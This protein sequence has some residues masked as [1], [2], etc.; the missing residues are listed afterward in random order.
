MQ[1]PP[2]SNSEY[3]KAYR[4][5]H[6]IKDTRYLGLDKIEPIFI[7]LDGES[8]EVIVPYFQSALYHLH[9]SKNA[10]WEE[11]YSTHKDAETWREFTE[12]ILKAGGIRLYSGKYRNDWENVVPLHL[13]RNRGLFPDEI[14]ELFNRD[15]P[16]FGIYDENTLWERLS[17]YQLY[18]NNLTDVPPP[19]PL[20]SVYKPY[21]N[22]PDKFIL[23]SASD[24]SEIFNRE[25]GLSTLVCFEFLL[26]LASRLNG[27]SKKTASKVRF[28]WFGMNYD[29]NQVIKD[30]PKETLKTLW[31]KGTAEWYPGKL[32]EPYYVISWKPGK[33]FSIS[34]K[35]SEYILVDGRI[36][37]KTKRLM[38]FS[39]YD[40][41]GF[42]QQ[43]FVK[44]AQGWGILPSDGSAD[45]RISFLKEMK[46]K[47]GSFSKVD[48]DTLKR[49][50]RLEVEI[51]AEMGKKIWHTHKSL[52]LDLGSMHGAG[53]TAAL[54]LNKH[55]VKTHIKNS[56]PEQVQD[57]VMRA[58]FGGR[59]QLVRVGRFNEVYSYD[60][61]S[62]Y[63]WAASVLPSLKDS[64]WVKVDRYDPEVWGLWHVK[65]NIK[66]SSDLDSLHMI[67]PFPFRSDKGRIRWSEKGEGWYWTPEVKTALKYFPDMVEILEGDVLKLAHPDIRPFQYH[68]ELYE[69]RK[70]MKKK[71][72][73]DIGEKVI[74][75]GMNATY[76]KLAQGANEWGGEINIPK[77]Q[78]YIYAGMITALVRAKMLDA[79]M[80]N[81]HNVIGFATDCI[82]SRVDLQLPFSD[83]L[84]GWEVEKGFNGLFIQPGVYK[85]EHEGRPTTY[86]NRGFLSSEFDWDL[87]ERGWDDYMEYGNLDV[88][89]FHFPSR[90]FVTLG[91]ALAN[92]TAFPGLW[93]CWVESERRLMPFNYG[94]SRLM[95]IYQVMDEK[96][97]YGYSEIVGMR[98][99]DGLSHPYQPR[100]KLEEE[101]E[102]YADLDSLLTQPERF[103]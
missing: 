102:Q 38:L 40:V 70:T 19:S 87:I 53:A 78:S 14:A 2:K 36:K 13:R 42:C 10:K 60:I 76:G 81:P 45:G 55:D 92:E 101:F 15:F 89:P 26:C 25:D 11:F 103:D 64:V 34:K 95:N 80:R 8:D 61:C 69:K 6:S 82:F 17:N 30:L 20:E 56:M 79:A 74:K 97:Q 100:Y 57:H 39:S 32:K 27:R 1:N 24:G 88:E 35:Q 18:R 9:Q 4:K 12:T 22:N 59:V 67:F 98:A 71:A 72:T 86:H 58:Y 50:N 99:V 73:Y 48:D 43:G 83:D 5:R 85:V 75:L 63:P 52:D 96:E 31:V 41:F 66:F 21:V 65:W 28:L 77:F 62:A 49:Y 91:A 93:R 51:L 94:Q 7:G 44:S 16:W 37:R 23:L 54:L 68:K 47:R 3:C 33:T 29:V 46:E 90:R 84:G